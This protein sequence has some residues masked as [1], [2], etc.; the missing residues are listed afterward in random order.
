MIEAK[1]IQN[2]LSMFNRENV[3]V[4]AGPMSHLFKN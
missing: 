1:E 3:T 4:D 2:F